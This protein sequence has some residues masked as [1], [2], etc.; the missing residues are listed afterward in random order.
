[1]GYRI[2][3]TLKGIKINEKRFKTHV[4]TIQIEN[5]DNDYEKIVEFIKIWIVK[6]MKQIDPLSVKVKHIKENIQI[7][8]GVTFISTDEINN[9]DIKEEIF[10]DL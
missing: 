10:N 6:N 8:K 3:F 2:F 4:I 9:F 5:F 7:L 1:M